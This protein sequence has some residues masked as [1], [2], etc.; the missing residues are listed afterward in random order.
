MKTFW[1]WSLSLWGHLFLVYLY[2][3]IVMI[4]ITWPHECVFN[5]LDLNLQMPHLYF[6]HF[7]RSKILR[8]HAHV[9]FTPNSHVTKSHLKWLSIHL[10]KWFGDRIVIR[11]LLSQWKCMKWSSATSLL[12]CKYLVNMLFYQFWMTHSSASTVHHAKTSRCLQE[13]ESVYKKFLQELDTESLA[14]L[15]Q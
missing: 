10:L 8:V 11:L 7:R 3:W 15:L 4:G 12:H 1:Q 13:L 6:Y 14:C 9:T 5:K 2:D